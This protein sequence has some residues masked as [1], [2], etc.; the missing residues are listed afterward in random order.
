V[1]VLRVRE[2]RVPAAWGW[3]GVEVGR[4]GVHRC[5]KVGRGLV[6][7]T[8]EGRGKLTCAKA[9]DNWQWI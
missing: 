8:G 1:S 7:M 6:L 5:A 9:V 3:G 2:V 4:D